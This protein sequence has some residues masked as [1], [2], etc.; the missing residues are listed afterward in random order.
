MKFSTAVLGLAAAT[1]VATT[2]PAQTVHMRGKVEDGEGVCYY[3]P[4]FDWVLDCSDVPITST[5]H[6]LGAFLGEYVDLV[7]VWNGSLDKPIVE[8]TEIAVVPEAISIGGGAAVGG[9][10]DIT[11]KGEPG[12][13]A[14]VLGSLGSGF[15]PLAPSGEVLQIAPQGAFLLGLDVI[16]GDGE[17]NVEVPLSNPAAI[18]V[19]VRTQAIVYHRSGAPATLTHT[20]CKVIQ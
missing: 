16:G 13:V 4:G 14:V 12:D 19:E 6:N 18:G 11:V 9:S 1:L 7:G 5:A 10:L 20:D 17:A 3:C 15:I 2:A 8:V